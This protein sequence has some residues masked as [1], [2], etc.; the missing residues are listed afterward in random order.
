MSAG[1]CGDRETIRTRKACSAQE[2]F[3]ARLPLRVLVVT[4][5]HIQV[6]RDA[7]DDDEKAQVEEALLLLGRHRLG[8]DISDLSESAA[9]AL[10]KM[11]EDDNPPPKPLR[12][13]RLTA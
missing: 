1:E 9:G 6:L 13:K 12:Q 7:R 11:P 3:Y 2:T 8:N 4:L 10:D 5:R